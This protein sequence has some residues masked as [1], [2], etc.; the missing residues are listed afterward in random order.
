MEKMGL[1]SGWFIEC[2]ILPN[3]HCHTTNW[4][5]YL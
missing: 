5:W 2:A 1:R 3:L 4:W